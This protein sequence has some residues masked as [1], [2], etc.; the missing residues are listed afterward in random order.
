MIDW[1]I[2]LSLLILLLVSH[3]QVVVID[4]CQWNINLVDIYNLILFDDEFVNVKGDYKGD[5]QIH[6]LSKI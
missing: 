2:S 5:I 3:N 6:F 4:W 1:I